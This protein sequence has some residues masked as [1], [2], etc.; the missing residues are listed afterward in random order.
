MW[1]DIF[2]ENRAALLAALASFQD[3]MQEVLEALAA[4]DGARL[5]DTIAGAAEQRQR[6]LSGS[7]L[8]P[9]ELFRLVVHIPDRPGAF[10]EIYVAL[11]DAGINIEDTSFHHRSVELGGSLTVYVLGE[12]VCVRAQHL[13]AALGYDVH[14]EGRRVTIVAIDGPVGSGK[15]SV[16]RLVAER[17]GFVYIDTGAMYR[18]V[19]LLA[20]EAGVSLDDEDAV[21]AVAA[22]GLGPSLRPR[23]PPAG[24]IVRDVADEPAPWRPARRLHACPRFRAC[25]T[26][27]STNSAASPP[28]RTWSWRAA[29]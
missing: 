1:T 8:E 3:G 18:A 5:G 27:W 16:A 6:L 17:L 22:G 26:C 13:I 21:V 11:G 19:G 7:D 4:G 12:E 9:H 10:K 14:G 29:T 20:T 23:R 28:A 24:G 25:A 2:L 15:S